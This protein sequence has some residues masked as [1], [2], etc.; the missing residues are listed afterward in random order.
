MVVANK[1][2]QQIQLFA[3]FLLMAACSGPETSMV[4]TE[5]RNPVLPGF[6]PDPSICRVDSDY[7]L[8][9]STFSWYPGVPIFHSRDL[10]NW[11]QIGHV[12]ERPAQLNLD[13]LGVSQGIFAPDI[14]Y[15]KGTF[16][17]VTTLIGHGGNFFVTA[18]NPAGPW[19]DPH[20]LPQIK[21]IDP[22]FF[23][24]DNDRC[25]LVNCGPPLDDAPLYDGHTGLRLYHFD[26]KRQE[27]T[28][29]GKV[30][31][32]GGTDLAKHPIWTEGP[33]LYKVNAWYYLMAAEGG[34]GENHSEVIFRSHSVEGPYEPWKSNPILTQRTLATDR[35]KPITSTGHADLVE[36]QKGEWWAV[37]L[38]CQPYI[39]AKENDYNTGRETFMAPVRWDEGWPVIGE[40]EGQLKRTYAAPML[41]E[42][43]PESYRPLNR[44]TVIRDDFDEPLLPLY[45]NFLRTPRETWYRLEKGKLVMQCR[46]ELLS[47][48]GNP[49]LL[50]RRQQHAFCS[51]ST[52]IQ[53]Q[54][55]TENEAA[56]LVVF[57]NEQHF[58]ALLLTQ[59][60]G[61]N[62]LQLQKA[63]E[64]LAEEKVDVNKLQLQIIAKGR[65][66]DFR[67]K[68]NKNDWKILA[69][70]VDGTFLSTRTAGGFVGCYLG[71]YAF[72]SKPGEAK[73]DWFQ[74][75]GQ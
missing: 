32:N 27:I 8:V 18:K 57:Q 65:T 9:N 28:G 13:S 11:K 14:S 47:G 44:T 16:Y 49:S 25:Y 12:L 50:A 1:K 62:V 6:Y 2:I 35:E 5:I 39:P 26:L 67:Y 61:E 34:T 73:F 64:I 74:Y 33:H 15:H 70:D 63:N 24:D 19:S 23:F 37:F 20:W 21:G 22:S 48:K 10:R 41:P 69:A 60:N 56:G 46:P 75:H 31:V 68:T 72:G 3:V 59:K 42:Y 7:Y 45:W 66:Y 40:K 30:I 29:E 71:L 51:A 38:G 43:A 36:T 52:A 55:Q 53:F 58:Y 4:A 54:P 17:L